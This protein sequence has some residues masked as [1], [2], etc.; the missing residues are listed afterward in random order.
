MASPEFFAQVEYFMCVLIQMA[1]ICFYGNE[2]TVASEQTGVSLYECDWFSSS[3]RFKRSMMLTMCRL[4]RPVYISIGKFSPLTL[5][6]LVTVCR[7]SFSYFA[8]FKSVQ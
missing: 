8:L 5:A 1:M 7:G 3:Q 2:I 4:Q 6:T